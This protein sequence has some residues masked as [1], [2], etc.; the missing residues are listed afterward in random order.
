MIVWGSERQARIQQHFAASN[1]SFPQQPNPQI[2]KAEPVPI[3][4][5]RARF[6][7]RGVLEPRLQSL[8][9]GLPAC[10]IPQNIFSTL[11]R[12]SGILDIC[13]TSS[14]KR[15]PLQ[16]QAHKRNNKITLF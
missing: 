14:R 7:F 9:L 15:S 3:Q 8:K 11:N 1:L 2:R 10:P 16:P 4:L 12:R 5:E 13:S 6:P